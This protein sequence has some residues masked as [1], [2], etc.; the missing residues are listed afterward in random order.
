[1]IQPDTNKIQENKELLEQARIIFIEIKANYADFLSSLR[2]E[3][4]NDKK[5]NRYLRRKMED[6]SGYDD[7]EN[8]LNKHFSFEEELMIENKGYTSFL[9][10]L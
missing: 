10:L 2:Y 4:L 8:N 1:M 6:I 9:K 5:K 3:N 7:Y